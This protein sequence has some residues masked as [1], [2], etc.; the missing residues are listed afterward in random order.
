MSHL[1]KGYR[2]GKTKNLL[3]RSFFSIWSSSC[4]GW[5]KSL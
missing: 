5:I 2:L 1:T 4:E 3:F